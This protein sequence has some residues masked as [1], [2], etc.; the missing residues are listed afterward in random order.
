MQILGSIIPEFD[1][2]SGGTC[3]PARGAAAIPFILFIPVSPY[4]YV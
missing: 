2:K 3:L 4:K 1:F